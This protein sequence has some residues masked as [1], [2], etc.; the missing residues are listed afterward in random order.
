MITHISVQIPL[1][2][3][4]KY[5][6]VASEV[7]ADYDGILDP[8]Y[9]LVERLTYDDSTH[10]TVKANTF[11]ASLTKID[12][13]RMLKYSTGDSGG[14][15]IKLESY[16]VNEREKMMGLPPSYVSGPL[17]KIFNEIT[18]RAIFQ[19]ET[20]A[21]G[22]TYR[23]FMDRRYW[24][25]RKKLK[26]QHYPKYGE[27]PYFEIGIAT[28]IENKKKLE[29][30]KEEEYSKHLIGM[31]FNICVIEALLEG[32]VD[33]FASDS[34]KTYEGC[35]YSFP[36]EP[37]QSYHCDRQKEKTAITITQPNSHDQERQMEVY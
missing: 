27:E 3:S 24:H 4:E 37:Y 29:F 6:S 9:G 34:L 20:S 30:F 25:L 33:L 28:P 17:K 10:L 13:D 32:L 22:K 31:G 11:L 2:N 35:D 12:D 1:R 8:G 36:W 15:K 23:D 5:T 14:S 21:D 18:I 19:P 26:L 7:S 16:S